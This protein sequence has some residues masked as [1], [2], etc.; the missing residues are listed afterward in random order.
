MVLKKK[1]QKIKYLILQ[2]YGYCEN[3]E[4][5][6]A[7]LHCKAFRFVLIMYIQNEDRR[8]DRNT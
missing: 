6:H 7:A 3:Y 2:C 5:A 4:I 1:V 8:I